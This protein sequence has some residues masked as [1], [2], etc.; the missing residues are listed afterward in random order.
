M[1]LQY[2]GGGHYITLHYPSLI[3]EDSWPHLRA[4][5]AKCAM[6]GETA[7]DRVR[8]MYAWRKVS[9]TEV[10]LLRAHLSSLQQCDGSDYCTQTYRR[11]SRLW[12]ILF[13]YRNSPWPSHSHPI[14]KITALIADHPIDHEYIHR[15]AHQPST[16]M[17]SC[18]YKIVANTSAVSLT[19][20]L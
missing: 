7:R 5:H 4:R 10:R 9:H 3:L 17:R 15:Q 11:I 2:G 12:A 6:G 13:F 14:Q 20:L 19:D 18:N 16:A 1:L 8:R